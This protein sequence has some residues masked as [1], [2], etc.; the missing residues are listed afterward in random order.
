MTTLTVA[1]AF[2]FFVR[3]R[4]AARAGMNATATT[5]L[6]GLLSIALWFTVAAA[7]RWIGFS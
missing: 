2:A 3:D 6:V 7:G 5:R 1:I 4:I